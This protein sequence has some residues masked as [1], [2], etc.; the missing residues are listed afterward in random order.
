MESLLVERIVKQE[1]SVDDDDADD[2]LL[3]WNNSEEPPVNPVNNASDNVGWDL[4]DNNVTTTTTTDGT[5]R[6]R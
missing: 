4:I 3:A 1:W 6:T 2:Q 5:R